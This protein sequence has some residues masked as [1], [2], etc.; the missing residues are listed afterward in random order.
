MKKGLVVLLIAVLL[1]GNALALAE[2]AAAPESEEPKVFSWTDQGNVQLIMVGNC[3]DE[4]VATFL[5]KP[6]GKL[7]VVEFQIL[8]GSQ[9]DSQAAFDY[10]KENVQLDDFTIW[11]IFAPGAAIVEKDDGTFAVVLVGKIQVLFDVP[12]DYDLSQAHL[13]VCGEEIPVPFGE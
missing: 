4:R 9:L 8:D 10:A 6:S 2:G 5:E 12:A 7:I 13:T 1:L 11:N 3:P